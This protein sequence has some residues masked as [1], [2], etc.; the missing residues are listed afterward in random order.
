MMWLATSEGCGTVCGFSPGK[1][2]ARM[3]VR[4]RPGSKAVDPQR[5]VRRLVGPGAHQRLDGC[6]GGRVG[7]PEGA[8]R[9][10][11][12]STSRTTARPASERRSSGST[13]RI[14]RQVPVTLTVITLS[15]VFASTWPIGE[16][17]PSTPA[18]ATRMSSLPQRSWIAPPSRSMPAMS[19][20]SSG[21]S[22]ASPLPIA[23]VALISSSSSSSPPTVRATATTCAPAAARCL[24]MK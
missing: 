10:A 11:R 17:T 7:R 21:T 6:L 5:H 13:E 24:A 14:S 15:K 22:V 12:C 20:R 23:R 9:C 3:A 19:V 4:V 8:G 2:C 1:A 18:L 16:M